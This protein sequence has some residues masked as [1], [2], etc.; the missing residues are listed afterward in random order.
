MKGREYGDSS[1]LKEGTAS[2]I[3]VEPP[4]SITFTPLYRRLSEL[5]V[6][7]GLGQLAKIGPHGRAGEFA[8]EDRGELLRELAATGR[9]C[10]DTRAGKI[11]HPGALSIRERSSTES[12]HLSLYQGSHRLTAHFDRR[13]P[14]AISSSPV[15]RCHYSPPRVLAHVAGR[16]GSKLTRRLL[17]GWRQLDFECARLRQRL[18]SARAQP[19]S[20]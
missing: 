1:T 14:L 11:L 8:T 16:L 9:F 13:S 12:L 6:W 17:G 20:D 7:S 19:D 4:R 2:E 5:G 10:I 15:G 18:L 3:A